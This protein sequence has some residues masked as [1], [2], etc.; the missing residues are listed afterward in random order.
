MHK[1]QIC[2]GLNEHLFATVIK[3]RMSSNSS[4]DSVQ[5]LEDRSDQTLAMV[6]TQ[7]HDYMI[8]LGLEF[9]YLNVGSGFLFLHIDA[10]TP[11]PCI[12]IWLSLTRTQKMR[13]AKYRNQNCCCSG[14]QFH[15]IGT[16]STCTASKLDN[17]GPGNIM[18]VAYSL[19]KFGVTTNGIRIGDGGV[20]GA[21]LGGGPF[22]FMAYEYGMSNAA[23][24][25][26]VSNSIYEEPSR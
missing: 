4:S 13:T 17:E 7:A 5:V 19:D 14:R 3:G 8:R 11:Q 25:L 22:G 26:D 2:R 12:T 24:S 16:P 15:F 1:L 20:V 18:R 21:I 9:S 10:T 23:V 6:T